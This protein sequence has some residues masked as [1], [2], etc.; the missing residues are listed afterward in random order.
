MC[1]P[2][3]CHLLPRGDGNIHR[4]GA[5]WP[6]SPLLAKYLS[7][8]PSFGSFFCLLSAL[9]GVDASHFQVEKER[10]PG[11]LCAWEAFGACSLTVPHPQLQTALTTAASL[12][13]QLCLQVSGLVQDLNV[14][15]GTLIG[16]TW[17]PVDGRVGPVGL[18]NL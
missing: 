5:P 6:C 16:K 8:S 12:L 17:S 10:T 7:S 9:R 11:L 1:L 4:L 15:L 18:K 14:H 3:V 13:L 2:S